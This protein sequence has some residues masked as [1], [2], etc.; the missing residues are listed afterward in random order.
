[1]LKL[2]LII[3]FDSGF[4]LSVGAFYNGNKIKAKATPIAGTITVNGNTYN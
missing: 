1:M 3:T 2:P 4:Y